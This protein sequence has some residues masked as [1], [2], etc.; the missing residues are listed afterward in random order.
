MRKEILL[1]VLI[2]M[3]FGL[4]ITFGIYQSRRSVDDAQ[5]NQTQDLIKSKL[6]TT[7]DD[8]SQ[9]AISSPEDELLTDNSRLIVSGATGVNNFIVVF[10]NNEESI[11]RADASGNFSIEVELDDGANIIVVQSIDEDGN[12]SEVE[13]SV[14]VDQEFL[15]QE[16]QDAADNQPADEDNNAAN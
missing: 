3:G 4:F 9:L 13:R 15:N 2:G 1:A 6:E 8:S 12:S 5:K 11:T 14:V 7:S 10:V 16:E